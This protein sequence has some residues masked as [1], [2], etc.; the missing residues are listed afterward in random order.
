MAISADPAFRLARC[1]KMSLQFR[2]GLQMEYCL[3]V[4]EDMLEGRLEKELT[5]GFAAGG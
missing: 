5:P 4:A 1:F 2:L 3:G